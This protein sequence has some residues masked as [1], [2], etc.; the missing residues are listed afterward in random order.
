MYASG[1]RRTTDNIPKLPQDILKG[2]VI[3]CSA[4][5]LFNLIL[6][7]FP[8]SNRCTI[9]KCFV[10]EWGLGKIDHVFAKLYLESIFGALLLVGIFS[11]ILRVVFKVT[12]APVDEL[13]K[14][15]DIVG[16]A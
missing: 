12:F 3:L 4:Y 13:E 14:A 8:G 6:W 2:F 9:A 7:W 10:L 11:I 1:W 5:I 15:G 16:V